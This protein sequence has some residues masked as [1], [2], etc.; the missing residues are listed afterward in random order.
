M[1]TIKLVSLFYLTVL[2]SSCGTSSSS[3]K[4]GNEIMVTVG[5]VGYGLVPQLTPEARQVAEQHCKKHGKSSIFTGITRDSGVGPEEFDFQC[6][7]TK[8]SKSNTEKSPSPS[9][10]SGYL[11]SKDGLMLTNEHVVRNCSSI[12]VGKDK[13][14][15]STANIIEV[16]GVNDL[17][18]IKIVDFKS[19]VPDEMPSLEVGLIRETSIELGESVLVSGFP[20]GDIFGDTLKVTSGLV[21][22]SVGIGNN[23][24]QFQF[25]A[26]VQSG[27]SGGPV[28]DEYGNIIGIVVAQLDKLKVASLTGSLPENVNYAV[29]TNTIGRFLEFSG[30]KSS[31]SKKTQELSTKDLSKIALNQTY[32]IRCL[33]K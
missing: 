10:G 29:N 30:V 3:V 16:D 24:S 23:I 17:A 27:N 11:I 13:A 20:Y 14:N 8:K 9:S 6:V 15:T 2:L 18:L 33:S 21:S 12:T 31:Y 28:Y 22:S 5:H 26:A 19:N 1:K 25:D 7:E 4:F 32:M